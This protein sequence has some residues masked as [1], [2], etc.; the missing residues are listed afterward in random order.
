[1]PYINISLAFLILQILILTSTLGLFPLDST[2]TAIIN[3]ANQNMTLCASFIFGAYFFL[4]IISNGGAICTMRN[5][6]HSIIAITS[7]AFSYTYSQSP[8]IGILGLIFLF[9]V[10]ES[11][12]FWSETQSNKD[13]IDKEKT[14]RR[15]QKEQQERFLQE[16]QRRAQELESLL[17]D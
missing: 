3:I 8:N 5:G 16:K 12:L 10:T 15:Q 4:S 1:M 6:I 2:I 7:L 11:Y 9:V 14:Q 17:H 13:D